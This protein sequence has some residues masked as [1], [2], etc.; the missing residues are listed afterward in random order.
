MTAIA[1]NAKF[2]LVNPMSTEKDSISIDTAINTPVIATLF[3]LLNS[4]AELTNIRKKLFINIP[5]Y[6]S[7]RLVHNGVY[8][9]LLLHIQR[10]ARAKPQ[11]LGFEPALFVP[12]T[13]PRPAGT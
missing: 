6:A 9:K 7:R 12:P 4:F 10:D 1:M 8:E 2:S 3:M 11:G 5:P 13:T